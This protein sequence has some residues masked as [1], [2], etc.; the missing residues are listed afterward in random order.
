MSSSSLLASLGAALQSFSSPRFSFK[1][2]SSSA[3]ID[4]GLLAFEIELN[5]RLEQL[6]SVDEAGYLGINWLCQAMEMVLSTHASAEVFATDLH[7]ALAHGDNKWLDEY[8]DHS[9]KLLDICLTLKEAI[10]DIKSYCVHVK[11][12]LR[13]LEKCT[14]GEIQFRRCVKALKKCM[15]AL[16]RRDE[17]VNHLGQRRSKLENCSSMLR[18]MGERLNTDDASKGNFFLAI[19]A[20]QVNTIFTCGLLSSALSFKPRRP[21]S[22]ICVGGQSAWSFSLSSLQQ[23]VKEQI[24]KKKSKGVNVLLEE[25]NKTDMEVRN[26][27]SIAEKILEAK[28][29]PLKKVKTLEVRD[30][31]KVLQ[32]SFVELQNGLIPLESL[33]EEV[34]RN[35]LRSRMALLDMH[36]IAL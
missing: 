3:K 2:S 1:A 17:I 26:V 31:A 28:S 24:E 16:K 33:L 15:D 23:R 5:A 6:K 7:Q 35:L 36:S 10:A 22:S 14:M 19:Y 20:V 27:L 13:A 4:P 11:L 21:L 12:A 8:L 25:L 9:I 18:R 32:V 30:R 29:F 34:Y